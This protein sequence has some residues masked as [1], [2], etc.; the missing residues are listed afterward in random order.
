MSD[1]LQ[2]SQ[3]SFFQN[4]NLRHGGS[5]NQT[6]DQG[7]VKQSLEF[8]WYLNLIKLVPV[9]SG[10]LV[11]KW[12][13]I[14]IISSSFCSNSKCYKFSNCFQVPQAKLRTALKYVVSLEN[15]SVHFM[16]S[17]NPQIILFGLGLGLG[18]KQ[19]T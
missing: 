2:S 1:I 14:R 12:C 6:S 5:G 18:L 11:A 13:L 19:G 9:T 17:K 7:S 10:N 3:L 16:L 15:E 8:N 4:R